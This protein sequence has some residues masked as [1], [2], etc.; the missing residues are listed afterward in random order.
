MS[1]NLKGHTTN[2]RQSCAR[3]ATGVISNFIIF[4]KE[5]IGKLM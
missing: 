2:D 5:N 4:T 1:N 3:E